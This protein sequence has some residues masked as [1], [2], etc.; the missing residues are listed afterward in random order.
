MTTVNTTMLKKVYN[1]VY[2]VTGLQFFPA[3][4]AVRDAL[5][6][7]E[8]K[9]YD[10]VLPVGNICWSQAFQIMEDA[11]K[12]LRNIGCGVMIYQSY[13]MESGE[14]INHTSFQAMFLSC[15]KVSMKHCQL[16]LLLSKSPTI[17]DHVKKHDC[18]MNMVWFDGK[19]IRWEHGGVTPYVPVLEFNKD[20]CDKR[21][22]Y[23][24]KK[25]HELIRHQ[26]Q[27]L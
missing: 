15:M 24:D 11:A 20:V 14:E 3:G 22:Q 8:P 21:I 4:G 12:D 25:R 13:G 2:S 5:Y 27:H 26:L 23:M 16:D 6:G 7:K 18:N 17:Q 1:L 10:M 9:D 19:D